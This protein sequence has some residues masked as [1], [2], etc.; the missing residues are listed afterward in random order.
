MNGKYLLESFSFVFVELALVVVLA[1]TWRVQRNA[2][3]WV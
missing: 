2:R 1:G 3:H